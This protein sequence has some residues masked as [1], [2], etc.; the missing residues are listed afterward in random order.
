MTLIIHRYRQ[1]YIHPQTGSTGKRLSEG[2]EEMAE[3]MV[4]E[5]GGECPHKAK[6][7]WEDD[8]EAKLVGVIVFSEVE[9]SCTGNG[10]SESHLLSHRDLVLLPHPKK[11][12]S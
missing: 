10:G 8:R 12:I 3:R 6:R 4:V 5:G 7:W 1:A 9:K 11:I 2:A